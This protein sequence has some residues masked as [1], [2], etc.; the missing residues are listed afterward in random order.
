MRQTI[1]I[2]NVY[3]KTRTKS[4]RKTRTNMKQKL[5]VGGVTAAVNTCF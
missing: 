1:K 5:K 2:K 3:R 4:K